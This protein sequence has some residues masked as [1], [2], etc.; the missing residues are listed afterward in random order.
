MT[1][2]FLFWQNS[3]VSPA[4][5]KGI[6]DAT[7]QVTLGQASINPRVASRLVLLLLFLLPTAYLAELLSSAVHEV[8]GHGLAAWYVGG[9]FCGF[10]IGWDGGG[11]A[12]AYPPEGGPPSAEVIVLATGVLA[13]TEV[14]IVCLLAAWWYR[15]KRYFLYM[16]LLLISFS[17]L[18][19]ASSYVFW[20]L[21]QPEA[22]PGKVLAPNA[23]FAVIYRL[24]Q[25]HWLQ[26]ILLPVSGMLFVVITLVSTSLFFEGVERFVGGCRL[27]GRT[28]AAAL[29]MFVIIPGVGG[30]FLFDWEQVIPG[31][32]R[33]PCIIGASTQVVIA[34]MLFRWSLR[35]CTSQPS[36]GNA[37]VAIAAIWALTVLMAVAMWSGLSEGWYWGGQT[38]PAQTMIIEPSPA[39]QPGQARHQTSPTPGTDK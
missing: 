34:L 19:N 6:S 2:H 27:H 25:G 14:G 16:A 10:Q 38:L 11:W 23:D 26:T 22:A 33:L 36:L 32:G 18:V 5:E 24:T 8:L 21:Y 15:E 28:R 4:G 3:S 30:W 39:I 31:I 17:C 13:Q 20:G 35:P 29:L 37:A 7:S 1:P 12:A 9:S